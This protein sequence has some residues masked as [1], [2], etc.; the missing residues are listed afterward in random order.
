M[1]SAGISW[2]SLLCLFGRHPWRVARLAWKTH[3]LNPLF[4]HMPQ[5]QRPASLQ[6]RSQQKIPD[7]LGG[8]TF[9]SIVG[10]LAEIPV[11]RAPPNDSVQSLKP[12]RFVWRDINQDCRIKNSGSIAFGFLFCLRLWSIQQ[13]HR[14]LLPREHPAR[15]AHHSCPESRVYG[16][17][18]LSFVK[19]DT[20]NTLF[21]R[22][23]CKRG[24]RYCATAIIV[25]GEPGNIRKR[26]TVKKRKTYERGQSSSGSNCDQ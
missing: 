9:S 11:S 13:R 14:L 6:G 19:H 20:K 7:S 4:R 21:A 17:V 15:M 16:S 23:G 5:V 1:D 25:Q 2:L 18:S 10:P 26:E 8:G 24:E 12:D 3:D 22:S